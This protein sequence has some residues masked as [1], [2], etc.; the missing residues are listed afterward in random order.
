MRVE[1]WKSELRGIFGGGDER[2]RP[3]LCP[4]C[5]TLVGISATRCHECGANLRF[6]L[7]AL[8]KGL[9]GFFGGPAPATTAI[10][11][12]NTLMF[13]FTLMVGLARGQGQGF[14]ILFGMNGEA[15]YRLG[16]GL[17]L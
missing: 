5:G 1:K 6:S 9:S 13:A 2:P 11:I 4:A 7:A 15:L 12:A 16:M 17:P 8:S 14:S 10:L 3:K